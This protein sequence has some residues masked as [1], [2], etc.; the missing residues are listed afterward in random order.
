MAG[1]S[2]SSTSAEPPI[3]L[4]VDI[5]SSSV[6]A[7]LFD[8]LGQAVEGTQAAE[9]YAFEAG[10]PGAAEADAEA[11]LG[12]IL[13]C[14]DGALA[15][16]GAWADRIQ[17]VGISTFVTNI[18]GVGEDD[19]PV[20]PVYTYADTRAEAEAPSLRADLDESAVHDRTGCRFHTSYLPARFRWLARTQPE[21]LKRAKRWMS[22]GDYLFLRLFGRTCVSYSVASWSGLLDR[23]RL[24][25]DEPLLS[26]L[27]ID[28][29]QLSPLTEIDQPLSGLRAEFAGRWPSLRTV[30]WFP[31]IGDGATANVGAGCTSPRQMALTVGTSAALR[32]LTS[33]PVERLPWALWCYRLDR[34]RQLFGGALTEGGNVFSWAKAV[35]NFHDTPSVEA[36]LAAVEPDA[37]GLTVLPFFSGERSPGWAGDVRAV[38]DGLSLRTAPIEILRACL[39]AVALRL[40][41][42]YDDLA[43]IAPQVE[44]IVANGGAILRSP[45]WMQ[46]IADALG[47]PVVTSAS[48]EASSRGAALVALESL[49]ARP[50]GESDACLTGTVYQP[51]PT[52]HRI[53]RTAMERQHEL[54]RRLI[55]TAH[56]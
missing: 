12:R 30:P 13:R 3:V 19:R 27:P 9:A 17:G 32:V 40:A 14:V 23:R 22:I 6:R 43:A 10:E 55:I 5:G 20:T 39:E 29:S 41:M 47:R 37:H 38:I 35:L 51:D 26:F 11:L 36:A 31:A 33:E 21:H 15:Q 1:S 56:K 18:L 8:R 50:E 2:V 42:V 25:W 52:R 34:R 28:V 53:Y 54:Y 46:I 48:T 45:T 44:Q 7:T 49:G 16:A 24:I 4:A